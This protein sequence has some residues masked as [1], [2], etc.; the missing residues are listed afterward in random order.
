MTPSTTPHPSCTRP[1]TSPARPPDAP[2]PSC[3][4]D[5]TVQLFPDAEVTVD[6]VVF[7]ELARA[8]DRR[9]DV[10]AGARRRWACTAAS[11]SRRTAT[12]SGPRSAASTCACAT[13]SCCG[14]RGRWEDLAELDPS[15][16]QAHV[17]LMRRYTSVGDR[18]A[19]LRQFERLDRALRRELGVATE[20]PGVR[21]ARPR[22]WPG[23]RPSA[24]ATRTLVGRDVELA[25]IERR[26]AEAGDG[27]ARRSSS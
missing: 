27:R 3:S 25:T 10:D 21:A 2:T 24:D 17:E 18:H 13:S 9:G 4:R 12:R 19:A 16:E 7:D 1:P 26:F 23:P 11:W 8:G 14:S 20:R 22:S 5:E 15:D 6:A